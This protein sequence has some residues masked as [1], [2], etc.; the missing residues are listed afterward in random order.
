M[1]CCLL[2]LFVPASTVHTALT[3]QLVQLKLTMCVSFQMLHEQIRSYKRDLYDTQ[4]SNTAHDRHI[5]RLQAEV[6]RMHEALQVSH[7]M[8]ACA[9]CS[10]C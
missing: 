4:A 1:L 3:V 9:L 5:A 7:G 6:K 2:L 8:C 10:C